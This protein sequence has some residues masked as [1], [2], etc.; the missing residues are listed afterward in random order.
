MLSKNDHC[1]LTSL[2]YHIVVSCGFV[3]QTTSLIHS[4]FQLNKENVLEQLSMIHRFNRAI[5]GIHS[6]SLL[7]ILC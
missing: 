7:Q 5:Y 1:H 6:V 2:L 4:G 3:V